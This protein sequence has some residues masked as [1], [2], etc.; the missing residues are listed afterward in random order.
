MNFKKNESA[1][2]LR[3]GYYTPPEI[4]RFLVKWA[5]ASGFSRILEPSCGDGSFIEAIYEEIKSGA[6]A[7][8]DGV[9]I[10]A[11]EAEKAGQKVQILNEKGIDSKIYNKDFFGW[12]DNGSADASWDVIIGNPPY[13]RY[14]YFEVEQRDIAE[15]IFSSAGVSFTK[16][17]NA[18]VPFV[19]ASVTHLAPGGRLAMVIPSEILHIQHADGLRLMLERE[20]ESIAI[21]SI[22]DMVFADALQGVVLL[23]ARKRDC[24]PYFALSVPSNSRAATATAEEPRTKM[25][26]VDVEGLSDLCKLDIDEIIESSES[27]RYKGEW[28]KALLS[29]EELGLLKTISSNPKVKLFEDIADVDI[30]IVTGANDFFVVDAKTR[31]KYALEDIS[32]PM[33]A[34]SNLIKGITYTKQDHLDNDREGQSVHFLLFPKK[35]LESIPS[36]MRDYLEIGEEQE[37]HTRFKCRIRKP[38]YVVPYVWAAELSMLKR[39]HYYPRI[40]LNEAFA[41]ST[42]TAYRMRMRKGYETR[43]RDLTFS[44]LNSLSFLHAELLGRHYAGGVLEMVPSEIEK[45][46]IPLVEA[47][48]ADFAK[49]DALVRSGCTMQELVDFTDEVILKNVLKLSDRQIKQIRSIHRKLTKRR[50]R[51]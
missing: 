42:D 26:I 39:C 48:E 32:S 33:L 43:A 27:H 14:Q 3:G 4:A 49:A 25:K 23:L 22:R 24:Q 15:K 9:E 2:K 21:I 47:S 10:L 50:L 7:Q 17:T 29:E 8:F 16:R 20:M 28:M 30:G 45:I 12:I 1:Q 46:P 51:R 40:V 41:Y 38:W 19:I 18:W 35:P 34:K 11:S 31:K 44:F 36:P 37:L 5:C 6:K 13:I